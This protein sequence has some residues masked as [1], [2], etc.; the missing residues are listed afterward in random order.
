MMHGQQNIKFIKLISC[1]RQWETYG[2]NE[3]V[4]VYVKPWGCM[5]IVTHGV[6]HI[7]MKHGAV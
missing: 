4:S 7:I 3:A 1:M 2:E 6:V 5:Y